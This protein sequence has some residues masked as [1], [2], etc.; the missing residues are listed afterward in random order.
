MPG[1]AF[2][3]FLIKRFKNLGKSIKSKRWV[4][5]KFLRRNE[6]M[7]KVK[8]RVEMQFP[9]IGF[10]ILVV[11]IVLIM[12]TVDADVIGRGLVLLKELLKWQ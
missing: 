4:R 10:V 3:F 8:V 2:L 11:C 5:I 9:W 6:K 1:G 12:G 7:K